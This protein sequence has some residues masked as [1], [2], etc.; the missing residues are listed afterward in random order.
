MTVLD[1]N[2]QTSTPDVFI[3][4]AVSVILLIDLFLDDTAATGRTC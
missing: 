4:A 3:L 1:L 2:L